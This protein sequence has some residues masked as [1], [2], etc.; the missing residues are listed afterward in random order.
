M[1]FK[2]DIEVRL[3][4]VIR[5]IHNNPVKAKM[6]KSPEEYIWS[7]YTKYINENIIIRNQQKGLY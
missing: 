2:I 1:F 3:L 5:Y 6:V 4:Q 7:S